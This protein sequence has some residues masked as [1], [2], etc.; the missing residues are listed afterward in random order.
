LIQE[1]ALPSSAAVRDVFE[2]VLT[3]REFQYAESSP[4]VR[5]LQA[6]VELLRDILRRWWPDLA[7]SEVRFISWLALAVLT[8]LAILLI[9]RW[10]SG[11]ERRRGARSRP[12]SDAAVEPLDARGW[13]SRARS[14]AAEGR[15]R[16]AASGLYQATILEMDAAGR[17]RYRDWKTPGDYALEVPREDP[18]RTGFLAFLADFVTVA[19]GPVEPDA[20]S[21][22]TLSSRAA[23]L[24]S[25]P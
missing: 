15:Y 4:W 21:Y 10:A 9:H 5:W 2:D 22:A 12:A 19:F 25:H 23:A 20:S 18:V 8:G 17:L 13:A 24:G 6:F 11:A 7:D 14:A 16:E 1:G 3:G